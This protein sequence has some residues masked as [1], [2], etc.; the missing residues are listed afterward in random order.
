MDAKDVSELLD[1]L[2]IHGL[3]V[4]V[5]G[6]W[7][8][9]ALLGRQTRSHADL[10]IALPHIHVPKL[11]ELLGRRGHREQARDGSWECNFVLADQAG[12]VVDV[13]SYTLDDAGN[14]TFGITYR[15]EDLK[16]NGII[17]TRPVRCIT[18]ASIVKFHTGYEPDENDSH[19]VRAVCERFQIELPEGYRRFLTPTSPSDSTPPGSSSTLPS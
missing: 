9:D 12:R 6:G 19:D 17:D 1:Y 11:R 3:E 2:E 13:H 14:N 7:G 10:D 16:G 8:V 15:G 5:D 18:P 4:Y